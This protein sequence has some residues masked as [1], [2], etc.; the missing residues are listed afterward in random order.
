LKT[1]LNKKKNNED[2][3]HSDMGSIPTPKD[4]RNLYTDQLTVTGFLIGT[5]DLFTADP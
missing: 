2:K 4:A 1:S 3:M 5:V